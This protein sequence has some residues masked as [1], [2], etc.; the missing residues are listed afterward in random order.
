LKSTCTRLILCQVCVWILYRIVPFSYDNKVNQY[1]IYQ[2][3]LCIGICSLS[4]LYLVHRYQLPLYRISIWICCL[5]FF[6]T[7]IGIV[8]WISNDNM[9]APEEWR[10]QIRYSP[11]QQPFETYHPKNCPHLDGKHA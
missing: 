9:R 4:F 1:W 10:A 11:G 3:F 6:C 7:C 8:A 5:Q 2:I